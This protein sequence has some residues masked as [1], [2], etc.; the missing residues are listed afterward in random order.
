MRRRRSPSSLIGWPKPCR[1][2]HP[3]AG[4]VPSREQ[5]NASALLTRI[6]RMEANF[7]QTA[8]RTKK[9]KHM[10]DVPASKPGGS[11]SGGVSG[12][13][14]GSLI[15]GDAEPCG[16]K[17]IRH[18]VQWSVPEGQPRHLSVE[19]VVL[20]VLGHREVVGLG[21]HDR[22]GGGVVHRDHQATAWLQHATQL[23]EGTGPVLQVVQDEGCDDVI[24]L[25]VGERQRR[26]EVR[27]VQVGVVTQPLAGQVDHGCTHV[28]AGDDGAP[29][30]QR[31]RQ[32]PG[33]APR[34]E[35]PAA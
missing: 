5:I 26:G 4:R 34:V 7:S 15:G 9:R 33:T 22:V 21:I 27:D 14:G 8:S 13:G 29:G 23:G 11:T 17:G 2:N 35:D 25:G 10:N 6:A 18:G 20:G 16:G 1:V 19:R 28:E 32:R 12:A 24:E 3:M 30:A 31:C